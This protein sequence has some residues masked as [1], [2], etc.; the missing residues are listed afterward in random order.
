[1]SA[2]L[3]NILIAGMVWVGFLA[4]I[5]Y[6]HAKRRD[7][8]AE[9]RRAAI[10]QLIELRRATLALLREI[11]R[12]RADAA[13]YAYLRDHMLHGVSHPHGSAIGMSEVL[14]G[15]DPDEAID[16]AMKEQKE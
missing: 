2:S 9:Q 10:N 8:F 16:A 1:M 11:G 3:E 6:L 14:F 7:Q 13:R 5:A 4:Y 15:D 12:L